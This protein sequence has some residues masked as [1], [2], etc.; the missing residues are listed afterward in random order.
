MRRVRIWGVAMAAS[1]I[2][3]LICGAVLLVSLLVGGPPVDG[4]E[5][6]SDLELGQTTEVHLEK[7][8]VYTIYW[9][10]SS[11][12]G[13]PLFEESEVDV[14]GPSGP[15]SAR[16]PLVQVQRKGWPYPDDFTF[17]VAEIEATDT[18]PHS[19][20]FD[21]TKRP[22]PKGYAM[23]EAGASFR[24]VPVLILLLS[25]ALLAVGGIVAIAIS[26]GG[27]SSRERPASL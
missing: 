5:T 2:A 18:G 1:G 20:V 13:F 21:T 8:R 14:L 27:G 15:V 10:C 6:T 3:A 17:P 11:H 7:G 26:L 25:G 19:V 16:P 23:L 4:V 9:V 12:G 24:P 22:V